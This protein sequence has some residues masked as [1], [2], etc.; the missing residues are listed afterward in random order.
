MKEIK[1]EEGERL[2]DLQCKGLKIIQNK[3]YY[4]FTS[5]SVI[6]ANF[7]TTKKRD[8]CVEI[9]MGCGVI[10]ILL[11]A[12]Q[13]FDKIIGFELQKEMSMLAKKNVELN[14]LIEKIEV[15]NDDIKN[16]AKY[17]E[18]GS[19][20]VVFSN[21]PYMVGGGENKNVVRDKA[22]H[23]KSLPLHELTDV[24]S[25]MLKHGGKFFLVYTAQ[26][27]A[28]VIH[29]LIDNKLE[30]KRM[31]FTQNGRGKV[32]LMVVEAVKGGKHGVKVLPE[33]VTNEE[34]GDYLEKLHSK[35]FAGE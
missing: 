5:D 21:P 10:S 4:T 7:I 20:D 11:S 28:E 13:S 9:G 18:N 27:C 23:E 34:N 1:L 35:Y 2:E 15:V 24:A 33:L 8:K 17:F 6:L 16:H 12:K 3:N 29:S 32:V 30:P 14:H 22:R 25:K 26:R 31:F 19:I